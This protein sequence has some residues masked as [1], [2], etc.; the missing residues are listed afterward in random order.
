MKFLLLLAAS[1]SLHALDSCC[2]SPL[3]ACVPKN[4]AYLPAAKS[5]QSPCSNLCQSDVYTFLD[6]LYWEGTERGLEFALKNTGTQ[7]DQEIQIYQPDFAFTPAFRLGIGTHLPHDNW[8]LEFAYSLYFKSTRNHVNALI[9]PEGSGILPVWTSATAFRGSNL[10]VRWSDTE[11]KW[12]LRSQFFDLSLKHRLCTSG[13]LSIEPSFGL[14]LALLRQ[15][16]NVLYSNGNS[17]TTLDLATLDLESSKIAMNNR[18]FNLGPSFAFKTRWSV[19]DH[20]DIVGL[21]SGSLFATYFKVGRHETDLYE[22]GGTDFT[23]SYREKDR[24]WTCRPQAGASLGLVWSDCVCQPS[25]VITYGFGAEYEAQVWW[26]QNMLYRFIDSMNPAMI[27]PTQ[28]NLFFHGLTA[29]AFVD[30]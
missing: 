18:S 14:K 21:L 1:A 24:F 26:K 22:S 9:V 29:N 30:F 20:L 6:F 11:A 16:F 19:W 15:R 10:G 7:F 13:A 4:C 28:G 27:A 5:C 17:V 25:K 3:E 12:K 8:S 23:E 2:D